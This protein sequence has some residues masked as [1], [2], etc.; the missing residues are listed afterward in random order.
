MGGREGGR[1]RERE[2]KREKGRERGKKGG[3]EGR[4]EGAICR[5]SGVMFRTDAKPLTGYTTVHPVVLPDESRAGHSW[6]EPEYWHK[7]TANLDLK[8]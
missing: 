5:Q 6:W 7:Q 4:R 3:R 1:R 8:H 2:R